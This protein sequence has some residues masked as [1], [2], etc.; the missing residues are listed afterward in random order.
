[1]HMHLQPITPTLFYFLWDQKAKYNTMMWKFGV[2]NVLQTSLSI[3]LKRSHLSMGFSP[4]SHHFK[5]T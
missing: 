5:E 2:Q 1:M 4:G 3:K